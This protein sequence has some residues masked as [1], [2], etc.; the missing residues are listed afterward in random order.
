MLILSRKEDQSIQ[1]GDDVI[2]WIKS[3]KGRNRITFG[4]HAPMDVAVKRLDSPPPEEVER[5][6]VEEQAYR[7]AEKLA[8]RKAARKNA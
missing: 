3:V 6:E 4:I 1:I 5:R 2:V 7:I 8:K